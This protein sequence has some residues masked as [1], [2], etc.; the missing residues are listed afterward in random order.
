MPRSRRR[1]TGVMLIVGSVATGLL[2]TGWV[3]AA[4][5]GTPATQLASANGLTGTQSG[6]PLAAAAASGLTITSLNPAIPTPT[7]GLTIRGRVSQP[8]TQAS[9]SATGCSITIALNRTAL[10]SRSA[11]ASVTTSSQAA[12]RRFAAAETLGTTTSN[13]TTGEWEIQISASKLRLRRST[14]A[15]VYPVTASAKCATSASFA[16]TVVPWLP[17]RKTFK[18]SSVVMLWPVTI[19]PARA[20]DN[21]WDDQTLQ[22]SLTSFGALRSLLNA[23]SAAP[24]S[25]LIDPETLDTLALAAG[26]PD[27]RGQTRSN[28]NGTTQTLAQSWLDDFT[29]IAG[30]TD[31]FALPRSMPDASLAVRGRVRT[32]VESAQST[33]VRDVNTVL[34]TP[35]APAEVVTSVVSW[36]CPRTP[37]CINRK[38]F[39]ALNAGPAKPAITVLPDSLAPA[40][41]APTWTAG[42]L[43]MLPIAGKHRALVTDG[44][45]DAVLSAGAGISEPA[46]LRQRILGEFALISL[47]RP[48]SPR[49]IATTIAPGVPTQAALA[50]AVA[51][52]EALSLAQSAGFITSTPLSSLTTGSQPLTA[53]SVRI[54]R[55]RGSSAWL[56]EVA[57]ARISARAAASLL[58]Q[59]DDRDLWRAQADIA[60]TNALSLTWQSQAGAQQAFVSAFADAAAARRGGVRV[61]TAKRIYLGRS[62]GTIPFTVINTLNVPVTVYP[63]VTGHPFTRISLGAAPAVLNLGPGE[64]QGVTIGARILGSGDITVSF[65]V[66][67]VDRH[68]ISTPAST[69]VTTSA[70]ARIAGWVVAG[71]FALLLLLLVNNIRR[72]IR[73][74]RSGEAGDGHSAVMD[75]EP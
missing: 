47:E 72:Q 44:A 40:T 29:R 50:G 15:G 59:P 66:R 64:R 33:A 12:Q 75:V 38:D 27:S 53:R 26:R 41:G 24:V 25:W 7:S 11:L 28:L 19:S 56:R 58:S 43:T 32:W 36:P 60:A 37:R 21:A 22:G 9:G 52:A 46:M 8:A 63:Q 34:G 54:T 17:S 1:R 68:L 61:V 20:L 14:P 16:A 65:L 23:G 3:A 45:L 42:A 6:V 10:V 70:Y 67:G 69:T 39:A 35:T 30:Q 71:A 62:S 73:R 74:R 5:T 13:P 51:G 57:R 18:P 48:N 4:Q 2:V 49:T 55:A 31:V